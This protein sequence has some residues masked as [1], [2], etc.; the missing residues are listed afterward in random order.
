M[1]TLFLGVEGPVSDLQT[2]LA[3]DRAAYGRFFHAMLEREI[4][5]PPSQFEAAFLSLA[6]TR[7]DA[8]QMAERALACLAATL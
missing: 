4:Y 1:F 8:V 5:L 2:A 3:A 6:H 7:D